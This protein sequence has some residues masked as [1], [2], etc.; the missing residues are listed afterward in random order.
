MHQKVFGQRFDGDAVEEISAVGEQL[1]Q[2]LLRMQ[3][4]SALVVSSVGRWNSRAGGCRRPA[5]LSHPPFSV[6]QSGSGSPGRRAEARQ[7]E[8]SI[9]HYSSACIVTAPGKQPHS[10]RLSLVQALL[11]SND[12]IDS[13]LDT[14]ERIFYFYSIVILL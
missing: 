6:P 12:L 3:C 13:F 9:L 10:Q 2:K 14:K 5:L 4:P 8:I 11:S 1:D 7:Q